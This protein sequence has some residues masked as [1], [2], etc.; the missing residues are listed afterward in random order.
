MGQPWGLSGPQFLGIYAAAIA[1]VIIIVLLSR[2][3]MRTVPGAFP[4]RELSPYE[5]GY[6]SGGPRRAAEV[7]IAELAGTGAL[8]VDSRGRLSETGPGVR[9]GQFADSFSRV[10]PHGMRPGGERT[11]RVRD[12]LSADPHVGGIGA[13]LR[14]RSL[15]ISRARLSRLRMI[16]AAT[17]AVLLIVG[18]ARIIEGTSNHRPVSYLVMLVIGAAIVGAGL[19]RAACGGNQPTSLGARYLVSRPWSVPQG[20]VAAGLGQPG[21]PGFTAIPGLAGAA[22][23]YGGSSPR[24]IAAGGATLFGVA[25]AGFSA[26]ED[27]GL[28]AALI[29]GMPTSG[30]S[31]SC[32]GSGCGGGG[33]GG[34]GCGG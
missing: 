19:L 34:G 8:R 11:A 2:R 32:G 5:V 16:T 33:C 24:E 14:A 4:A 30:G 27:P 31:S 10:W 18:I 3:A 29:A 6:L 17:I 9:S 21:L 28:R 12:Q 7:I 26:V 20:P 13:D 25:L 15:L 1:A 22:G 23:G